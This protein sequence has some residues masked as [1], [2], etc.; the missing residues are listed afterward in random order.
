MYCFITTSKTLWVF[1]NAE[2]QEK[3]AEKRNELIN[4][5]FRMNSNYTLSHNHH[6]SVY[7]CPLFSLWLGLSAVMQH[8]WSCDSAGWQRWLCIWIFLSF[9]KCASFISPHISL[10]RP[11]PQQQRSAE[12]YC[13][14]VSVLFSFSVFVFAPGSSS[15][16]TR[17]VGGRDV[18]TIRLFLVTL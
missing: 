5:R 10:K 15:L 16:C 9:Q 1:Q 8:V 14:S 13:G 12:R 11:H 6:V 4:S 17:W 18:Q 7:V 2:M 3:W